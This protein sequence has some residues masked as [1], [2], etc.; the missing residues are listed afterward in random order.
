M[1]LVN[2]T[3]TAKILETLGV[4]PIDGAYSFQDGNLTIEGFTDSEIEAVDLALD[5]AALDLAVA[6]QNVLNNRKAEYPPIEDYVDAMA[7][8]DQ[9]AV[10]AYFDACLAVKAKYPKVL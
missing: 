9:V 4:D 10:Q 3:H 1:K 8:G 2:V 6:Q 5:V 7:K